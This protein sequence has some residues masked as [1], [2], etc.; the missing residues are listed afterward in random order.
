[1]SHWVTQVSQNPYGYANAWGTLAQME[2]DCKAYAESIGLIYNKDLNLGNG[3]WATPNASYGATSSE[4]LKNRVSESIVFTKNRTDYTF[5]EINVLF[6]TMDNYKDGR[7]IGH[8]DTAEMYLK[9]NTD[10]IDVYIVVA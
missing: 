3:H 6:V 7:C 5:N 2:N 9:G 8:E 10:L 4:H 1:M